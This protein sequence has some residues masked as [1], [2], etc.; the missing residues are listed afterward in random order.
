MNLLVRASILAMLIASSCTNMNPD[1][2]FNPATDADAYCE[3]GK[4]NSISAEKFWYKVDEAY[5]EKGMIEELAEFEAIILNRSQV[6]RQQKPNIDLWRMQNPQ[7][8]EVTFYPEQDAGTYI[9]LYNEDQSKAER[10]YTDVKK[11]YENDGY[12]EEWEIFLDKIKQ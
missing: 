12:Y 8:V 7:D 3:I 9:R 4:K 6:A 1:V 5:R 11:Q 10:F 2:K